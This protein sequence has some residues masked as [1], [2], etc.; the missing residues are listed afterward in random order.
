MLAINPQSVAFGSLAWPNVTSIAVDRSAD[1]VVT[2]VTDLGP[3]LVLVD[4]PEQRV[5]VRLVAEL[6]RED[7]GGPRPGDVGTLV[8]FTSPAGTDG[9]QKVSMNAVV[10]G[11]R[12]PGGPRGFTRAIELI[13]V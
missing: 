10:T 12:H 6:Q 8:F 1:K 13:A 4:V 7:L 5:V 9:G 2:E 11:V 3:H